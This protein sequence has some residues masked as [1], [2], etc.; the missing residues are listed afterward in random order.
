MCGSPYLG[1]AKGNHLTRYVICQVQCVQV[2]GTTELYFQMYCIILVLGGGHHTAPAGEQVVRDLLNLA[3]TC[4]RL[5]ILCRVLI[6]FIDGSGLYSASLA[7]LARSIT[8]LVLEVF[9]RA[10]CLHCVQSPC[11]TAIPCAIVFTS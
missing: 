7:C 4:T 10:H 2:I 6:L 8:R 9:A 1:L 5:A 11:Y 3:V